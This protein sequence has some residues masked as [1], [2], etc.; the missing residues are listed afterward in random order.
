MEQSLQDI[1]EAGLQQNPSMV[2]GINTNE[3]SSVHQYFKFYSKLQNQQNMLMD[4]IRTTQY[5]NAI[6]NNRIDFQDKIVLDVGAGS[7][8]LSLFAAQ[9]G[10]R[11]VYAI[12]ASNMAESARRLID[13]NGYSQIIEVIQSKIEDIP[14]DRIGK[15]VDTIVSEPLGTFL[16]NE[17]MLETYVIAREKFLKPNGKMFPATS[18]LC[19]MPFYDEAVHLEQQNKCTFWDNKN[20]YGLDLSCLKE[21]ALQE[22]LSQPLIDTYDPR[23][24]LCENPDR[25]I[26][27]FETCSLQ[28]LQE[29]DFF[30]KHRMD[31]TGL[32]HG[33][34]LYFDAIFK[35]SEQYVTLQT[36][37]FSPP[38]HW[39]QTR[40]LL[41][42]PLGVN[43]GQ[44]VQGYLK[45]RA[46][47]EQTFDVSIDVQIPILNI[48]SV[49][50][51][52]MK[53]P[54]YRGVYQNYY[55]QYNTTNQQQNQQQY[56]PQGNQ[57]MQNQS[58]S[59]W[60]QQYD[61]FPQI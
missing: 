42:E 15:I 47:K 57:Q 2:G 58:S 37:P 13:A 51:F 45:M 10:A 48:N 26:F 32:I 25:M 40:L 6:L 21:K 3:E 34:A 49:N 18:H 56:Y 52:D 22:K 4:E 28:D 16:L 43:K 33:Y 17:R 27:D 11:K 23:K 31:K 44:L 54:E 1:Q 59:Q 8:I 9:A 12:E 5:R 7:G 36:G 39:Y 24:N 30:F 35:G 53:D 41:K 55:D 19:I 50:T 38:T 61:G 29:I 60:Q 20:F 14:D 46:N